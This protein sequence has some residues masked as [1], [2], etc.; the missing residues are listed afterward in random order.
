MQIL[1]YILVFAVNISIIW[2]ATKLV[3]YQHCF[4]DILLIYVLSEL[5]M[6]LVKEV[7]KYIAI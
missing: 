1:A 5:G 4:D 6:Y 2:F 7:F 3:G